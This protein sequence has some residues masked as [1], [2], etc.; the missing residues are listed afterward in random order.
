MEE[1]W[2]LRRGPVIASFLIL[3]LVCFAVWMLIWDKVLG[4]VA[5]Q[6]SNLVPLP[7]LLFVAYEV[8]VILCH[9]A[10]ILAA[11][12]VCFELLAFSCGP[13]AIHVVGG[14]KKFSWT[15]RETMLT[16]TSIFAPK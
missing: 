2:S 9:L 13:F 8:V 14:H 11:K 5:A 7:F 15:N 10:R 12:L 3:V 4:A 16:G 1:V 6:P